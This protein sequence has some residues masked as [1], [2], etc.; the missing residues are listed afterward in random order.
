MVNT[1]ENAFCKAGASERLVELL[2]I[3][4]TELQIDYQINNEIIA[5]AILFLKIGLKAN[6]ITSKDVYE[7]K[8]YNANFDM[9]ES[10]HH[11]Y[12]RP[13]T[14]LGRIYLLKKFFK[15][16]NFKIMTFIPEIHDLRLP[17]YKE[18]PTLEE[19]RT[20]SSFASF[21]GLNQLKVGSIYIGDDGLND[22]TLINI[23]EYIGNDIIFVRVTPVTNDFEFVECLNISREDLGRDAIRSA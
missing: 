7:L 23:S 1:S 10:C 6:T 17:L 8:L 3:G 13:D 22:G 16:N 19:H 18:I 20:L 11:Y 4:V 14:R 5:K 2:E 21:I 15:E 9:L 12:P